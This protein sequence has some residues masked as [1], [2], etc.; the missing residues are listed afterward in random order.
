M[1]IFLYFGCNNNNEE[2]QDRHFLKDEPIMTLEASI[3]K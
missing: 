1:Y 2:K 3:K